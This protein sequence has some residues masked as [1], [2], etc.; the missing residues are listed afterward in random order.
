M[1]LSPDAPAS[2]RGG[3]RRN[4]GTFLLVVLCI[5]MF[6]VLLD[7]LAMNVAMPTVGRTFH[8]PVAR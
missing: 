8:V 4:G 2:H 3:A 1:N 6:L 7:V 5:P